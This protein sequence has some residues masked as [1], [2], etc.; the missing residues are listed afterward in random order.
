MRQRAE[1][2][3]SPICARRWQDPDDALSLGAF[4]PGAAPCDHIGQGE[5]LRAVPV[6]SLPDR[7]GRCAPSAQALRRDLHDALLPARSEEAVLHDPCYFRNVASDPT[8]PTKTDPVLSRSGSP[9]SCPDRYKFEGT[10]FTR[11]IGNAVPV[12]MAKGPRPGNREDR[13]GKTAE[14]SEDQRRDAQSS[15]LTPNGGWI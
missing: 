14:S 11:Q 9:M 7:F 10:N 3:Y 2:P 5:G 8:I 1:N 4:R 15:G 13:C 12:L 6:R